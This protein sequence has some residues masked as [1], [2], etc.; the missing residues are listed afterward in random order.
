MYLSII[1]LIIKIIINNFR[2]IELYNDIY[3]KYY[4][5][6]FKKQG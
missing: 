4:Y 3:Y 2:N 1:N 6:V 5:F